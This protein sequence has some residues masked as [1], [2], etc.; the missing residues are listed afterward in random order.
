MRVRTIG[1]TGQYAGLVVPALVSKGLSVRA[2]VHDPGKAGQLAGAGVDET[3]AGD[4]RDPDS[5]RAALD[6]VEGVFLI[7]PAFAPDTAELGTTL[8]EA[9]QAAGVR[10]LV[11]SGVYHPSLSLVN[12]A[13]TRPIEESL[14]HSGLEFT[15]LQPAMF[16]Q[17]LA[18]GWVS[19]ADRGV[20][21]MP[22]SKDSPMSFVDYRDVAEVAAIA[23][24]SDDLVNGTF[25]LS[26][27]RHDFTHRTRCPHEPLRRTRGDRR[28]HRSRGCT[29]RHAG[30]VRA[31]RPRRDVQRLHRPRFTWR[32][33]LRPAQHPAPYALSARR[34]L[35]RTRPLTP[36]PPQHPGRQT[37]KET[38]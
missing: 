2:L 9:A 32:Q 31:R 18:G 19:A 25:E 36:H 29:G 33:Q 5:M 21:A 30:R 14:F 27:R 24:A 6:G 15:V 13:S 1:A 10:R 22:Y 17:G 11:F 23:F 28:G 20:F 12:H 8:V 37:L 7:I 3:V 38:S 16:M 35:R 34:L 26:R 4:L